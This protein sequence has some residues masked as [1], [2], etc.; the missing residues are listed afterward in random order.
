M[1]CAVYIMLRVR[2]EASREVICSLALGMDNPEWYGM[3]KEMGQYL[4]NFL[5]PMIWKFIPEQLQNPV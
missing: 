2:T 3:W 1:A 5:P 4:E